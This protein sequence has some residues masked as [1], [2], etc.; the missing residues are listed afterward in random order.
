MANCIFCDGPLDEDTKPEHIL[1][2]ALG[3]RMTT[4]RVVCS[5][6]NG[7]FGSTI[8]NAV[9]DQVEVLRN[10]LGL[11][12]GSGK[13]PPMLRK[14]KAGD[15]TINLKGDGSL[16]L[17][18]KPFTITELGEGSFNLQITARSLDELAE[19]IPNIAAKL[20]CSEA[21]VME[22]LA[23]A[24]AKNTSRR[25]GVVHFPMSFGGELAIRSFVKSSLVLW[26]TVVGN[27]EVKGAPYDEA[28]KFVTDGGDAFNRTRTHLDS[29]YLP[30][31]DELKSR[32][33]DFFNLIYLRSDNAGRVIG[34]FTL[35]NVMAWQM[36][37]AESG[38]KPNLKIG[39]IS[40]PMHPRV[41]SGAIADEI[42]IDFVWLN[43]PDY[44]DDFVRARERLSAAVERSQKEAMSRELD[45]I[46]R[47]AFEK[48]GVA[49]GAAIPDAET[50]RRISFDIAERAAKHIMNLPHEETV[51]G[52][53]IVARVQA[54]RRKPED[55]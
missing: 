13:L 1:L 37:L 27:D 7:T 52:Q 23:T 53:D 48:N 43:S 47:R 49:E 45:T 29:R 40:N 8:D 32:F 54:L 25:P 31:L 24:T 46:I 39:I 41:W 42:D 38:G 10:M 17:V 34:H 12:S 33:G 55:D 22:I 2:N 4:K 44:S 3:G 51:P 36:V 15:D 19:H 5:R 9:T 20:K 35:L 16:E 30:H 18:A 6:C 28:R 14:V 26:A 21:K 11:G 50:A